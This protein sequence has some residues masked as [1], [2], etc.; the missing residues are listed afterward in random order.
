MP[1]TPVETLI[2]RTLKG[3]GDAW[4]ELAGRV[5]AI[6]LS[7]CASV[8]ARDGLTFLSDDELAREVAV[9]VLDRLREADHKALSSF[10]AVAERYASASPQADGQQHFARWLTVVVKRMRI[11][12]L[13][14]LP[15]Y[16]R[17]RDR[18]T[19]ARVTNQIN[20][21]VLTD[22]VAAASPVQTN[23]DRAEVRRILDVLA[24]PAFPSEQRNAL[25]LW[26]KGYDNAEVAAQLGL[27]DADEGR[28]LLRA[29]RQR[30]RRNFAGHGALR[31]IDGGR[32]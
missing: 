26:L 25:V 19:G 18:E 6:V 10:V 13:R 11:D 1:A 2:H 7:T 14:S 29:A 5:H 30:L 22:D 24:S 20:L 17:K 32:R 3:D 31:A 9:R 27:A 23:V 21:A 12:Y 15:E 28:R 4:T 8:R 16:Q